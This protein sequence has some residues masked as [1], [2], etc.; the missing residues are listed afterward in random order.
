MAHTHTH[1]EGRGLANS[2]FFSLST[3]IRMSRNSTLKFLNYFTKVFEAKQRP[4]VVALYTYQ[5]VEYEEMDTWLSWLSH[6]PLEKKCQI[7]PLLPGK[8][9]GLDG[10][11]ANFFQKFWLE[12]KPTIMAC[13]REFFQGRPILQAA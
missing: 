9:P 2:K 3:K 12:L 11:I 10:F 7:D 6:I 13:V 1:T 5:W 4:P 8:T